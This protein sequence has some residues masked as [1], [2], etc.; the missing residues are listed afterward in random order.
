MTDAQNKDELIKSTYWEACRITGMICL[1][2]ADRGQQTDREHLIRELATLAQA[3]V[4]K[5]QDCNPSL[6]FAI[7]QLRGFPDEAGAD[8]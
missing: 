1:N 6:M 7:E 5:G 4:E 8:S 3:C 2:L